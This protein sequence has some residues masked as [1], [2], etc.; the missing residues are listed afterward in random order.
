MMRFAAG[1]GKQA[2]LLRGIVSWLGG[3]RNCDGAVGDATS[4]HNDT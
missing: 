2:G 1:H 3:F 4:G